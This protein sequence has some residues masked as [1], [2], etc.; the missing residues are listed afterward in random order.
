MTTAAD[1]RLA[2]SDVK[3]T[4]AELVKSGRATCHVEE[5]GSILGVGRCTAY[6]AA[7]AGTLPTI[8]VG[9][10]L[11]VPVPRLLD[12]L[13]IPLP[14]EWLPP[15]SLAGRCQSADAASDCGELG[16]SHHVR[17][18]ESAG[19]SIQTLDSR[20]HKGSLRVPASPDR[21]RGGGRGSPSG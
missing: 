5:A 4:L 8:R 13:G 11:L 10:R 12:L 20:R 7:T 21:S 19:A 9:R 18:V 2:P 17:D 16:T 14:D 15:R 3:A 6:E 1:Q